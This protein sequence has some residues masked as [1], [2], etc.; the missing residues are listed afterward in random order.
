VWFAIDG[1]VPAMPPD[2]P[3]P[4]RL[5]PDETWETWVEADRLPPNLGERAFEF[6]RAR[7]STGHVIKSRKNTTVPSMGSIPGGPIGRPPA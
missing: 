2:R 6:A 1:D 3:L 5:K 7:L 4:K